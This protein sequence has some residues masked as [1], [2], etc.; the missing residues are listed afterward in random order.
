V[1]FNPSK[2]GP[3]T[4]PRA[5]ARAERSPSRRTL[6]RAAGVITWAVTFAGIV[7]GLQ[8]LEP[9]ARAAT[10]SGVTHVQWSQLPPWICDDGN[11]WVLDRILE[12]VGVRDNEDLYAT[13]LC[14][15]IAADLRNPAGDATAWIAE[16]RSV[17]KS[18]TRA[19]GAVIRIDAAFRVP[20]AMIAARGRAY[21]VDADGVRLPSVSDFRNVDRGE[22]FVITG[23]A[24]PPPDVGRPWP[25]ADAAAGLKLARF[26]AAAEKAGQLPFRDWLRAIDVAN[27]N[28]TID[29]LAGRL[30]IQTVVPNGYIHWGE[31]PD[32]EYGIDL[33]NAARKL[34]LLN[35]VF[36]KQGQLPPSDWIDVRYNDRVS[37]GDP[38]R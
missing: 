21:V 9:Y 11:R 38:R 22:W 32:E 14:P 16:L 27:F 18:L 25:G 28:R 35:S 4:S 3:A 2:R 29:N 19:H 7:Y 15:R 33:G 23:A 6:V 17:R 10:P 30:R 5:A 24:N 8:R 31:P 37:F 13:D 34:E 20:F 12:A 1:N 26:L 36:L